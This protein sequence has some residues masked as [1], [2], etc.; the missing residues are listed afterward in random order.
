ML[1]TSIMLSVA[2]ATLLAAASPL[3][4]AVG[5]GV[6][7]ARRSG[8]TTSDGVFNLEKAVEMMVFT[9]NKHRQ[10]LI[11]LE[12]NKGREAFN[13][14]SD[15]ASWRSIFHATYLCHPGRRDYGYSNYAPWSESTV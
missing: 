5:V 1:C 2:T 4:S 14:A 8:L 12:R 13:E 3:G 6:P 11:N 15:A 9:R 10:N 7:L